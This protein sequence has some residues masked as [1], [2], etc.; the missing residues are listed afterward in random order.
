MR[1]SAK[2]AFLDTIPVLTGYLVLGFGFGVV[3]IS[4][5]FGV[6]LAVAMSIFIYAGSMQYAAIGL[7]TQGAS[8]ITVALTTIMVN[9]RH[10]FYGISMLDRY[11]STGKRKLYL[12]FSLTDETYSLVCQEK[13]EDGLRNDY[14]LLVS[15]FNHSY[16]VIGTFLGALIGSLFSF[17]SRGIDFA[18]TALFITVFTEQWLDS[19]N[20]T[21]ALIGLLA[22]VLCIILFGAD[23]FLIPSMLLIALLLSLY[24]EG[25]RN[26]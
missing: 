23:K 22:P 6:V 25:E 3:M 7:F 12:I 16:W 2:E 19:K 24:K 18:L 20:H 5:G 9:A 10:I 26:E 13:V 4:Q 17:N 14:Y 15:L 8:F 21:P 1:K 11:K